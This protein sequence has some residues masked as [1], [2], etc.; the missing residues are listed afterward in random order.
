[1]FHVHLKRMCIPL[2]LGGEFYNHQLDPVVDILFSSF[3]SLLI[4]C[5]LVLPITKREALQSPPI[6]VELSTSPFSSVSSY[7]IYFED[8]LLGSCTFTMEKIITLKWPFFDYVICLSLV[9]YLAQ[10]STS[11]NIYIAN[12]AVFWSVFT[13]YNFSHSF[14]FA[15]LKW[16]THTQ[17]I[18]E[19]WFVFFLYFSLT[20]FIF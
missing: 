14:T 4:F 6:I 17:H 8:L 20:H 16:V 15:Y 1:M 5:P 10:K 3:I 7:F 11:S 18:A 2:L 9:M 19:S 13:C 12:P